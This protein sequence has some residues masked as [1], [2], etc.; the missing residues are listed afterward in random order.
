MA[1]SR[2]KILGV[3][4]VM[5]RKFNTKIFLGYAKGIWRSLWLVVRS[6]SHHITAKNTVISPNFLV[7]KFCGKAQFSHQEIT[8]N[9]GILRSVSYTFSFRFTKIRY[10]V[11]RLLFLHLCWVWVQKLWT[12]FQCALME[13]K[14]PFEKNTR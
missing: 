8:W 12:L 6:C 3:F 2:Q 4:P 7:W 11:N 1:V 13:K 5:P 9:Y 14:Q 10:D